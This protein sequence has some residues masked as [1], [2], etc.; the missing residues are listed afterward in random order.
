MMLTLFLGAPIAGLGHTRAVKL[1]KEAY[2]RRLR[3]QLD[4]TTRKLRQLSDRGDRLSPGSKAAFQLAMRRLWQKERKVRILL[5][6]IQHSK[7]ET[8]QTLKKSEDSEIISLIKSYNK[9]AA[10]Y[11]V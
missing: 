1:T 8:W 10:N 5:D 9:V 11:P 2:V 3:A 6:H 7:G 4:D